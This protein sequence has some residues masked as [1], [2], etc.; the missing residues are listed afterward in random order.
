MQS[1]LLGDPRLP[2]GFQLCP[3]EQRY[4]L[5]DRLTWANLAHTRPRIEAWM[6]GGRGVGDTLLIECLTK[7]LRYALS[8]ALTR[9]CHAL[10]RSVPRP[11]A[12]Q[13]RVR[14]HARQVCSVLRELQVP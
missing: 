6:T 2:L 3:N 1:L 5:L 12:Q 9:P 10:T 4:F 7:D 11:F 14:L 13:T 8:T